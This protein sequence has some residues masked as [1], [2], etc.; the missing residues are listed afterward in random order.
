MKRQK[1]SREYIIEKAIIGG[2][3]GA[4]LG[5]IITG[6]KRNSLVAMLAGAAIGASVQA[7]QEAKEHDLAIIVE[8]EGAIYQINPDGSRV[9]LRTLTKSRKKIPQTFTIG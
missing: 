4:A 9:K 7:N 6:K 8:E 3:V 5:A 1:L 2:A